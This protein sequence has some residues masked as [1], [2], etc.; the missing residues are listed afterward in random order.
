MT[1]GGR[2]VP[3]LFGV[4]MAPAAMPTQFF[5]GIF[6]ISL[7][8]TPL[9]MSLYVMEKPHI[10]LLVYAGLAIINVGLDLVLIPRYGVMGAMIPVAVVIFLQPFVYGVVVKRM[11]GAVRIP[12]RFIGKCFLASSPVLLLI[13]ALRFVDSV[14]TLL[15][16][17]VISVA[18]VTV[19]FKKVRV[20]GSE[21]VN[22]IGAVPVP[23][24][25]RFLKF[26]SS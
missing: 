26:M 3:I 13:P 2:M 14:V 20:L 1:L 11:V 15:L 4:D 22:M 25:D 17:G 9:S 21:E 23:M 24:V 8:S 19:A 7:F 10:N 16:A 5:F 18:I 12:F 6:T